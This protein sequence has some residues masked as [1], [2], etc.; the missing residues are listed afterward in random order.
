MGGRSPPPYQGRWLPPN[1]ALS[2]ATTRVSPL[3]RYRVRWLIE[4]PM[5]ALP[6]LRVVSDHAWSNTTQST[7]L[8]VRSRCTRLRRR[9]PFCGGRHP[10]CSPRLAIGT[11]SSFPRSS[12]IWPCMSHRRG[13]PLFQGPFTGG[14]SRHQHDER[15]KKTNDLARVVPRVSMD[16]RHSPTAKEAVAVLPDQREPRARL[17]R[18]RARI[19]GT[20]SKGLRIDTELALKRRGEQIS[21]RASG[22]SV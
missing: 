21:A 3:S 19:T 8:G 17:S 10:R 6:Y 22:V 16:R 12:P 11:Q 15:R 9:H 4:R 14:H 13:S 7:D 1:F 5:S 2:C 20:I 18:R